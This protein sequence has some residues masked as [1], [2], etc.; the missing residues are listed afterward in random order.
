MAAAGD[1]DQL[2]EAAKA[3]GF[4]LVRSRRRKPGGDFGRYG[5]VDSKGRE[6]MG[7]G[8]DGLTGTAEEVHA[9]LRGGEVASWK[10]SLIG[11]VDEVPKRKKAETKKAEPEPQPKSQPT[12]DEPRP[13]KQKQAAAK[14]KAPE[15]EPPVAIRKATAGDAAGIASL[16]DVPKKAIRKRLETALAAKEPPLVAVRDDIVGIAGWTIVESLL[17]RRGRITLLH[18]AQQERRRGIGRQ[19]IEEAE[20]R[21]AAAG[22]E[23]LEMSLGIDFDA[24]AGFL[25]RTGWERTANGYGKTSG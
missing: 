22:A 16:I 10:R 3:R 8:P 9:Y 7:F 25:R 6:C 13:P 12:A 11:V 4:R 21:A 2:R 19:L 24:P 1:D 18:V 14:T 17:G 5:L 20:R 15:R 23:N